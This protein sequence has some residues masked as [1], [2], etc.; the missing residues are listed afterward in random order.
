M[1]R[2]SRCAAN[3]STSIAPVDKQGRTVDFLLNKRRDVA[4]AKRF[5]CR[6]AKQHGAPRVIT[7]DGYADSHRAVDKLKTSGI[8]PRCVQVRS[9]KY[10]NNV[11]EQDHRR[12]KQRVRP[13]L[14]FKRFETAAMMIRGIELA[15]KITKQQFNLKPLTIKAS[16][17]PEIWAAAWPL[18]ICKASRQIKTYT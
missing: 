8:L 16:T 10:L 11:I 6:A 5:F 15:E 12:I 7:L 18:K 14:G 4:A 9:C 13:M 17:A 3:G 1:R 2:I